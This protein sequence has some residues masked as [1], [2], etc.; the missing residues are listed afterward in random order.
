M[1]LEIEHRGPKHFRP[2]GPWTFEYLNQNGHY[3]RK[4]SDK[5]AI[6]GRVSETASGR[7]DSNGDPNPLV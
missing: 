2:R 3:R 5:N 4:L 1:P 7:L 6:G